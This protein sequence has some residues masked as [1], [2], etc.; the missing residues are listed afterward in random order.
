MVVSLLT[1]PC[2]A[3]LMKTSRRLLMKIKLLIHY[4]ALPLGGCQVFTSKLQLLTN[5]I[6]YLSLPQGDFQVLTFQCF[7]SRWLH[8]FLTA[9]LWRIQSFYVIDMES[10][11]LHNISARQRLKSFG[12]EHILLRGYA[13]HMIKTSLH[14]GSIFYVVTNVL[15]EFLFQTVR[16]R[17]LFWD[18]VF[19]F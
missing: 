11:K 10:T 8:V 16:G 7:A 6:H 2:S 4:Y 18:T 15:V 9:L 12:D 17:M 3:L 1:Q 19:L 14:S 5:H 13:R